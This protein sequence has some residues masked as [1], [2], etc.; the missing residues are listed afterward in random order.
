MISA[1][2]VSKLRQETGVGVMAC[3]KAIEEA[4][5]DY[6]KA[7]K[8]L[9]SNAEIVAK[10]KSE[11]TS[12]QGIIECYLHSSRIG[13]LVEIS[14]ESDFVARNSEF[15]D[16]AHNIAMQIVS[17]KP[18]DVKELLDQQYIR[19]EK[20]TIKNLLDQVIGKI[21]ENIQ[22]KRF[23]RFELGEI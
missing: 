20:M 14:S 19:D 1:E 22:I 8:I 13:V 15:K 9:K 2:I 6:E 21:G 18:K 10:K 5:G 11:R 16:F 12:N 23:V 7:K 17:I 4:K 3:K